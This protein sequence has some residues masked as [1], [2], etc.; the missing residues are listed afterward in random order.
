[1]GNSSQ[2]GVNLGGSNKLKGRMN[3]MPGSG[4]LRQSAKTAPNPGTMI[5]GSKGLNA[6]ALHAN[7]M[8]GYSPSKPLWK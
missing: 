6:K 3:V 1:M 4:N 5:A 8:R 7:Y 2:I